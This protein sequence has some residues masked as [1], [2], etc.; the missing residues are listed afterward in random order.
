MPHHHCFIMIIETSDPFAVDESQINAPGEETS[1]SAKT[2]VSAD[3]V[4]SNLLTTSTAYSDENASSTT[5]GSSNSRAADNVRPTA[6][7]HT[8]CI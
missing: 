1:S 4:A 3:V 7:K 8:R 2:P 5:S 6:E